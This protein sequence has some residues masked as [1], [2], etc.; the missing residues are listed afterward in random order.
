MQV[1]RLDY[2]VLGTLW[3]N[4][5]CNEYESHAIQHLTHHYLPVQ[6]ADVAT[7]QGTDAATV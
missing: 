5:V 3:N 6:G 2:I 1:P 4:A 7:V